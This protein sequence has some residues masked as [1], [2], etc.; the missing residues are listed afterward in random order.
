MKMNKQ[1]G[2][3][4]IGVAFAMVML[5]GFAGLAIDM[6]TIRYQRRLQQTAADAAAVAGAHEIRYNGGLGITSA[7]LSAS[8]ANSFSNTA[9]A[10]SNCATPGTAVGTVCV[11]IVH[12]PGDVTLP[13]GAVISG[14]PHTGNANY[15]EA[16]VGVVQ[17]TYFMKIFGLNSQFVLARA[18]ATN[19]GQRSDSAG[20][21]YTLGP[22]G[23]GV[24]VTTSGT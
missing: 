8:A 13:N 14:G 11:Q 22:P 21:V 7:A 17:P 5:A 9:G 2:Q 4:M 24:G 10:V 16:L 12:A 19:I 23:T 15:V 18:V 3:V 20:C 6:G 1:S